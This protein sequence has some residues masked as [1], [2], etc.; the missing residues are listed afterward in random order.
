[1]LSTSVVGRSSLNYLR[2]NSCFDDESRSTHQRGSPILFRM[3]AA[4]SSETSVFYHIATPRRN[5]EE[6]GSNV[7][8]NVGILQ[9]YYAASQPRRWTQQVPLQ[10]RYPATSLHGVTT[11]KMETV[12]SSETSESYNI[13]TRRHSSEDGRSKFLC[14]VGTLSHHHMASQTRSPRREGWSLSLRS[15]YSGGEWG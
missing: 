9:H 15:V 10:R 8:R 3:K 4:T 2:V 13:T 1:M 6:G 5:P 11:Q 14:N 7:F 12:R